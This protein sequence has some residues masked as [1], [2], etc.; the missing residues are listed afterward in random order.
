MKS[1]LRSPFVIAILG[2]I[3]WAWMALIGRTVRWRIEGT[4][5][6]KGCLAAEGPGVVL[7]SWHETIL[8]IPSGWTREVRHW[9]E[10]RARAAMMVSLSPDGA[11]VSEAVRH[12]DLDVVRGSKSNKKKTDKDKGGVRALAEAAKRLREGG[13]ICMT[14]DGPRGPRRVATGGAVTLAQRVG[15]VV[16]PYALSVKPA[17]RLK[18]WDRFILPLPFTRGGMVFGAPI[19]C[20]RDADPEALQLALQTGMDAATRRAEELAGYPPQQD[21]AGAAP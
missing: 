17:P 3:I 7:A 12:L 14:P 8:L 1:L 15:A 6:L 5:T 20:L 16:V 18:T 4:E 21:A 13:L 10:R 19:P 9:K 2:R 11:S